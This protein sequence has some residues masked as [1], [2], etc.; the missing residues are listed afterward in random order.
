MALALILELFAHS[1][2]L[3]GPRGLD[4]DILLLFLL[5][6]VPAAL[7]AVAALA[8]THHAAHTTADAAAA[9]AT[10]LEAGG[11]QGDDVVP[12]FQGMHA[13]GQEIPVPE[14]QRQDARAAGLQHPDAHDQEHQQD[15]GHAHAHQHWPARQRQA[16]HRQRGQEE[17]E[18]EVEDREPAILGRDVAQAF[19]QTDGQSGEW[20]WVPQQDSGDVEEKMAQGNL[21]LRMLER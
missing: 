6:Q 3:K 20:D 10:S 21:K 16:E 11:G 5:L 2:I 1:F 18:D 9:A 4:W 8:A 14:L 7:A 15:D 17:E 12:G 19:S 13:Q